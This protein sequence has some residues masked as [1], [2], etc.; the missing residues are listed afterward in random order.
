MTAQCQCGLDVETVEAT[1]GL[2]LALYEELSLCDSCDSL[3]LGEK[4][5][6]TDSHW[7]NEMN[8]LV[9]R[10]FVLDPDSPTLAAQQ[11]LRRS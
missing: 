8:W 4:L 7:P 2:W 5:P 9:S 10:I 6:S 11:L 3:A 1:A